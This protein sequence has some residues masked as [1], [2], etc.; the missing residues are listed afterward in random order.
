MKK[1]L[2]IVPSVNEA[3]KILN[4]KDIYVHNQSEC[5][6][7]VFFVEELSEA[8]AALKKQMLNILARE[9]K[10][11][12]EGSYSCLMLNEIIAND[13]NLGSGGGWH[14][15]SNR[16]QFKAIVYLTDVGQG[17]GAF[18]YVEENKVKMYLSMMGNFMR[19][20]YVKAPKA[21]C[22]NQC[23]GGAGTCLLVNTRHLHRGGPITTGRRIAATLYFYEAKDA[24]ENIKKKL[25]VLSAI[26]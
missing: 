13:Q 22:I 11:Q 26:K 17:N 7:R 8:F 10:L 23:L 21:E 4:M 6:R 9:Y 19:K 3:E 15:D 20:R 1:I 24:S 18:E 12:L 16:N 5:E 25:G 2:L 14:R